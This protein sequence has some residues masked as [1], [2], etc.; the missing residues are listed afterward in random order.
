[1]LTRRSFVRGAAGTTALA[2][3][4]LPL[5]RTAP[6]TAASGLPRSIAPLAATGVDAPFDHVVVLMMENRSFDHFLGWMPGADGIQAGLT[7][8]DDRGRTFPTFRMETTYQGCDV[9]DPDHSY[10]GFRTQF[11]GGACDG[12]LRT[13]R[14]PAG[15]ADAFPIGYYDKAGVGIR[16][17]LAEGFTVFDR[18]FSSI[19][20]ET[21]PNRMYMHAA[22]TDRNH[23]M[24]VT[25]SPTGYMQTIWDRLAAKGLT[26]RYYFYDLP[27]LGLFG[28]RYTS[29]TKP[30]DQFLVDAAAG[31]LPNVSFVDP[32]F[33]G[34]GQGASNDDHPSADIR[35]GESFISQVYQAVRTSPNWERTILVINYDE[36]GGFYDHVPPPHVIDKTTVVPLGDAGA[37]NPDYTQ[38]GFRVPCIVVS[39]YAPAQVWHQGPYEHTSILKMIEWRWGLDN[40]SFRDLNARNLA[41]A[42]NF[43]NPRTAAQ[44]PNIPAVTPPFYGAACSPAS[45]KQATPAQVPGAVVPEVPF[46][47]ALPLVGGVT[48]AGALAAKRLWLPTKT[49]EAFGVDREPVEVGSG[50]PDSAN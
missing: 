22:Q 12:F 35:G 46:A 24:G 18:Y 43:D 38:L 14:D 8:T 1:M 20:A 34:E 44:L 37:D 31:T 47:V 4:G 30:F 17:N 45:A 40:L 13:A 9:K 26:G 7:F 39:R 11:N 25:N 50:P 28:Q 10:E 27:F 23:N 6:A 15:K 2:A 16:A 19:M 33:N 49:R 48:I 42:L 29:I 3:G 21:F 41:E 32:M 36:W 5:L